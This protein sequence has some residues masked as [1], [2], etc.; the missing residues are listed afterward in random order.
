L[1]IIPLYFEKQEKELSLLLGRKLE[2]SELPPKVSEMKIINV[3]SPPN[4]LEKGNDFKAEILTMNLNQVEGSIFYRP[5]GAKLFKSFSVQASG[6]GVF[7][8]EIPSSE[9]ND[10]FEYYIEIKTDGKVNKVYPANAPV[11]NNAVVIY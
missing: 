2:D 3:L 7:K 6:S 10:D 5:L 9:I 1:H 4:S 11:I 8:A